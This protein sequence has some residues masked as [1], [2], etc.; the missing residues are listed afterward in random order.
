MRVGVVLE[1]KVWEKR[2][3]GGRIQKFLSVPSFV[4]DC[5]SG[6]TSA[7][8]GEKRGIKLLAGRQGPDGE[9]SLHDNGREGLVSMERGKKLQNL[10]EK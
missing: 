5:W 3:G 8:E 2:G 10:E 4:L 6:A 7:T 1:K 9:E